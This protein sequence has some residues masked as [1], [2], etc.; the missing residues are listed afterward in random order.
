MSA[1]VHHIMEGIA[2]KI[3][4]DIDQYRADHKRDPK[5][6]IV[7]QQIALDLLN[8]YVNAIDTSTIPMTF[9]GVRIKNDRKLEAAAYKIIGE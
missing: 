6:I 8:N 7:S 9:W 1:K 4:K 3:I 2:V 5:E